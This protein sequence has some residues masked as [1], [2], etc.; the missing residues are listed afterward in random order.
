MPTNNTGALRNSVLFQSGTGAKAKIGINSTT[1]STTLDVNGAATVRGTLNLP[2]T[3]TTRP[4][5]A[6]TRNLRISSPPF[7]TRPL[8]RRWHRSSNGKPSC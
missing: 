4:R 1:P 3:G 7:S 5:P 2:A 8:Q 6:K